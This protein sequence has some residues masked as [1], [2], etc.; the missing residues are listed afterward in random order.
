MEPSSSAPAIKL[1][2]KREKPK[3]LT[4]ESHFRH[5]ISERVTGGTGFEGYEPIPIRSAIGNIFI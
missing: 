3:E 2:L 1:S 5:D 4:W